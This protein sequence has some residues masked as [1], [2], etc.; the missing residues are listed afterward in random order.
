[1]RKWQALAQKSSRVREGTKGLFTQYSRNIT[2]RKSYV[3]E[4][5]IAAVREATGFG[6]E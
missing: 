2:N 1:M 3:T 5:R 6:L 4:N